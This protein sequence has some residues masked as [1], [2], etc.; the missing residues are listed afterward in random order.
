MSYDIE[1][2]PPE[3]WRGHELIFNYTTSNYFD[4]KIND[5]SDKFS[6]IFEKKSFKNTIK[7][8]FTD[9]LYQPFWDNS[10]V[11]GVFDNEKLVA[12]LEIW[13]EEWSNRLRVT[14]LWVDMLYRRR[15][16]G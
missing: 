4:V 16:I 10:K 5:S 9:K 11:Y 8:Q 7:K 3:K 12:C 6:V 1:F 14:E 2:L 13:H 15:G